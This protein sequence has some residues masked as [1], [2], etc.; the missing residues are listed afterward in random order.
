MI[1]EYFM[2]KKNS[3]GTELIQFPA[4]LFLSLRKG[5]S[6]IDA[7]ATPKVNS[8]SPGCSSQAHGTQELSVHRTKS[9]ILKHII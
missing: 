3:R 2:Q 1:L 4:S 6:I 9:D 8:Q 5:E 7:S